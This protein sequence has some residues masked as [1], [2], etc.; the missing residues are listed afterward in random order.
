MEWNGMGCGE[1]YCLLCGRHYFHP[2]F[3]DGKAEACRLS[4]SG[5]RPRGEHTKQ[6]QLSQVTPHSAW[7]QGPHPVAQ[8]CGSPIHGIGSNSIA[9]AVLSLRVSNP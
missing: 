2:H 6:K 9:P 8:L 3:R 5:M 1:G 7:V 4:S